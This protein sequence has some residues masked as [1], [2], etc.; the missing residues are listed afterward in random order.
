VEIERLLAQLLDAE[1]ARQ[2]QRTAPLRITPS[3]RDSVDLALAASP[4]GIFASVP[5]LDDGATSPQDLVNGLHGRLSASPEP[6]TLRALAQLGTVHSSTLPERAGPAPAA[7]PTLAPL[8]PVPAE[9]PGR[10]VALVPARVTRP[11]RGAWGW[12]LV[13][14]AAIGAVT[15]VPLLVL[16]TSIDATSVGLGI[17]VGIVATGIGTAVGWRARRNG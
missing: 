14:G 16:D 9:A 10:A 17:L 2:S 15:A 6:W 1:W 7:H 3:V 13:V 12:A 5:E 8:E 4:E 11:H